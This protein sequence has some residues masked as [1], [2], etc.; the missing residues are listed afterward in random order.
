M[1]ASTA[2]ASLPDSGTLMITPLDSRFWQAAIR[3][4]LLDGPTLQRS[5]DAIDPEKR[6]LD[7]IDRRLARYTVNAGILT[8]W[9]AQQVLAGRWQGL[10]ID[11]YELQDVI[12]QGG[13]GR[14]YL[15]KDVRLGRK[16]ALKILS[17]ERMNNVRAMARFRREA[18]VGAQLQHENLVRIY[19][20]GEAHGV[21]YLVMEYIEGKTIGRLISEL[22]ALPP[23]SAADI[24]RKVALGLEHLHLKGLLHRDVN[25][26]NI[27]LD[28][29]GTAKLTDLGLAI[30]LGDD[31]DIVTRDGATV[32]TF[33]YISPEQAKHSRMVDA[34]ADIYS[35][36]CTLYHM[37]S[38]RVPFPTPS[39]P[40]KLYAHQL[41]EP[42]PL[43][44]FVPNLPEGLAAIVSKMM[45]KSPDDRY[46][47]ASDVARALEPF[48]SGTLSASRIAPGLSSTQEAAAINGQTRES[49]PQ[50]G[51]DP[52]LVFQKPATEP[53]IPVTP[54]TD[55]LGFIPKID[56][57][58]EPSLSG[59]RSGVRSKS[60]SKSGE[61]IAHAPFPWRLI[62]LGLA[63]LL[64]AASLA[65]AAVYWF[66]Y[67]SSAG[68]ESHEAV[69]PNVPRTVPGDPP[70]EIAIRT[71]DGTEIP[72]P[73]LRD[74][75]ARLTGRGGEIILRT[76]RPIRA[77]EIGKSLS[78]N[79]G[80][81]VIRADAGVK[82]EILVEL[83]GPAPWIVVSPQAR[84]SLVGLS[85]RAETLLIPNAAPA[86]MAPPALIAAD[87]NVSF[88]RCAFSTTGRDRSI[89]V[90][91]ARGLETR[92]SGCLFDGFDQPV[93]LSAY[94]G[95]DTR[96][97]HCVFVRDTTGPLAGWPI[98][99]SHPP[100]SAKK[101]AK[102]ALD[103]CT[104]IGAGLIAA[105]GFTP[106]FPL[107][108][109]VN[110]TAIQA[111]SLMMTSITRQNLAKSVIWTGKG[112]VYAISGVVWVV[113]PPK[114]F[115]GMA[116]GPTDLTTWA[117]LFPADTQ[118]D[119]RPIKFAGPSIGEGH[120]PEDVAVVAEAGKP[121]VG[122]EP[123]KVGPGGK[124]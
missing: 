21:R 45:R 76:R 72:Q 32:G 24:A 29:D 5:W 80:H 43:S 66:K 81:L 83:S 124:P 85:I 107:A 87:G 13:M 50:T 8:L 38:G 120:L 61:G 97:S 37:I 62:S 1:H 19:D 15:A 113:V 4:G 52:D 82:P 27:L 6:T 94:P 47:R 100:S 70:A 118:N 122:A 75:I 44:T 34:R 71:A 79:S 55:P 68:I 23:P 121:P 14:V 103:R 98:A 12:G 89:R 60:K 112:D 18:K 65:F 106:D 86:P 2:D 123:A 11:K 99:A 93:T 56:L 42:E 96:L 30:D 31:D 26:M 95:S 35:L 33:D 116:G 108:V 114:G 115:D 57:G 54:P 109:T 25:P 49:V 9:Q 28:R 84:L 88:D 20:E 63:G 74:A 110:D 39:L 91:D 41:N 117:E 90:L 22:G 101:P 77:G 58:P 64:F 17:R 3:S 119:S 53:A 7:A 67:S 36:G 78:L 92:L 10:R 46:R 48:A 105:E 59:S 16:V 111:S 40:E 69:S 102:L 51:S 104:I 73:T